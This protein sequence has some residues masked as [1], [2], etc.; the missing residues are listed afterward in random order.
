V[1][2]RWGVLALGVA[3]GLATAGRAQQQTTTGQL[4]QKRAS[5]FVTGVDPLKLN[6]VPMNT[7]K[8]VTPTL[9][10]TALTPRNFSKGLQP[11]SQPKVFNLGNLLPSFNL[12]GLLGNRVVGSSNFAALPKMPTTTLPTTQLQTMTVPIS[13]AAR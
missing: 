7:N 1:R 11:T 3:L 2:N 4:T 10:N 12:G 8:A 13:R 5:S 9:S 6:F